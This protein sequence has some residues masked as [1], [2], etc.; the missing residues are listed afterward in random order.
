MINTISMIVIGSLA[1]ELGP[2]SLFFGLHCKYDCTEN[3][4][5]LFFLNYSLAI[6]ILKRIYKSIIC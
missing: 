6:R 3:R 2:F 5:L 4:T 1:P